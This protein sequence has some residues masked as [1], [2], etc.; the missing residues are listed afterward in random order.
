M[1]LV[2]TRTPIP[3]LFAVVRDGY[4][5]NACIKNLVNE[6]VR[7]AA[8]KGEG[9][10]SVFALRVSEGSL[11]NSRDR[12]IYFFRERNL[13]YW[14][15]LVIEAPSFLKIPPRFGVKFHPH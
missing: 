7:E 2:R 8:R 4:D 5:D 6:R 12:S 11:P 14:A 3:R 1:R 15:T 13:G 9:A 10:R